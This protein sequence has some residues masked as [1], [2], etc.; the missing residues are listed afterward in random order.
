[1]TSTLAVGSLVHGPAL[2]YSSNTGSSVFLVPG[3]EYLPSAGILWVMYNNIFI[4]SLHISVN[5]PLLKSPEL[6][7]DSCMIETQY[8]NYI[9]Y[10]IVKIP[11]LDIEIR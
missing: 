10:L 5:Y 3:Q 9:T 4:G 2:M 11:F 6:H 8:D 7:S 1:M